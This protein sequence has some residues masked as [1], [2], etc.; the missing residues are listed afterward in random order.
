M[1]PKKRYFVFF[2]EGSRENGLELT[3][4]IYITTEDGS[5]PNLFAVEEILTTQEGYLT[6]SITSAHEFKTA[7]DYYQAGAKRQVGDNGDVSGAGQE[8][9]G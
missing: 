8:S 7:K 1:K 2:F 4:R 3:H 6:A 5:F 9:V